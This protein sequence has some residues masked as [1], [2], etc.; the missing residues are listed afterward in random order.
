MSK[1]A[2]S[3]PRGHQARKSAATRRTVIEATLTCIRERGYAALT[4]E[5][6]ARAAG[7]SR[8]AVMHHF[9]GKA[10]V[11]ASAV[12]ALHEQRLNAM[13]QAV[14]EIKLEDDLID[15]ALGAYWRITNTESF[16]TFH[17]L[18]VAARSD[19]DLDQIL[20]PLARQFDKEWENTAYELFEPIYGSETDL[21]IDLCRSVVE[22]MV[23]GG[24]LRGK[25]AKPRIARLLD[26]LASH[27]HDI[28][29]KP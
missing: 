4:M 27:L 24:H 25:G 10:D 26:V 3:K 1:P 8:G 28:A 21:A 15:D 12:R 13:R 20:S 19:K 22:G 7:V 16:W 23:L 2:E 5:E 6:V 18:F 17:Q 29:S 11:I 14:T 9:P